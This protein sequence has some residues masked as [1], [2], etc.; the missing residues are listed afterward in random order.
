MTEKQ[1][2]KYIEQQVEKH[3]ESLSSKRPNPL[4]AKEEDDLCGVIMK[5]WSIQ[6]LIE[7]FGATYETQP[8]EL[9]EAISEIVIGAWPQAVKS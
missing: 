5:S 9:N 1:V 4:S 2:E 6:K 7:T 8:D 3:L